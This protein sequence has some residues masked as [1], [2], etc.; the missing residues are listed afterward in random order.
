MHAAAIRVPLCKAEPP[1]NKHPLT[2]PE[3]QSS[4]LMDI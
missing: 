4:L 2:I 3:K 1:L